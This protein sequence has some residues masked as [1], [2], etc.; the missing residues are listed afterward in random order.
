MGAGKTFGSLFLIF[1]SIIT[2]FALESEPVG[3]NI[4]SDDIY[5]VPQGTAWGNFGEH[6]NTL[7]NTEEQLIIDDIEKTGYF[8]GEEQEYDGI[9][10]LNGVEVDA[11]IESPDE[12]NIY[13]NLTFY[14]EYG[15]VS[16]ECQEEIRNGENTYSV[17]EFSAENATSFDYE[18]VLEGQD[19]SPAVN[20]LQIDLTTTDDTFSEG[21]PEEFNILIFGSMFFLGLAGLIFN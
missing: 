8:Q 9:I 10:S 1:L 4:E 20:S 14:D 11:D 13:L 7:S 15:E 17:E 5:E 19:E 16:Q 21:I 2:F 12:E 18:F 6:N 3:L